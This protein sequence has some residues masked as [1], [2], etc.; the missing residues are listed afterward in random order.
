MVW[1]THDTGLALDELR[2]AGLRIDPDNVERL[3]PPVHHHIHLAV[4]CSFALPEPLKR[5]QL[6]PLRNPTDP[7]E[8]IFD[9]IT[10][11]A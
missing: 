1:N 5:G 4:R 3:S 6:R 9:L 11:S 2:A 7:A 10:A 8:Q